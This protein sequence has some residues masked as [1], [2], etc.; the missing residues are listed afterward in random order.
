MDG[1][2]FVRNVR[3][4]ADIASTPVIFYTASYLEEEARKLA[5][6]CGVKAIITKPSEPR[7][8]LAQVDAVLSESQPGPVVPPDSEEFDREHLRVLSNKLAQKVDEL[9][10]L[11]ADLEKR[12][13]ERTRDLSEKN[14]MLEEELRIAR[15]LQIAMLPQHFPTF[16]KG[17][18]PDQSALRFLSFYRPG[19]IISG[20]FFNVVR[21]SETTVGILLCDV[22]GHDVRAALVTGMLRV[23]AEEFAPF[24]ESPGALLGQINHRLATILKK[25]D[26]T[27]FTTAFYLMADVGSDELTF[28]NAGHPRPLWVRRHKGDVE[29]LRSDGEA[30]PALGLMPEASYGDGRRT[31]EPG[32]FVMLFTDGLF[33]IENPQTH[34]A[35]SEQGLVEAARHRAKLPARQL[36]HGLLDDIRQFAG[37]SDFEDDVCLLGVEMKDK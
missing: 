14:R 31:M 17:V 3:A 7:L 15:E 26:T 37:G 28:S 24:S 16:P 35:F 32:D 25:A 11:N 6:A 21:L 2:E 20:D 34:E 36:F 27:L 30:G 12:V 10:S 18:P 4:A 1:Y 8:I 13:A 33:E 23:M 22:M 19:S 9:E 29:V 5:E